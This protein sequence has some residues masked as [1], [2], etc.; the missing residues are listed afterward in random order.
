[1]R[2]RLGGGGFYLYVPVGYIYRKR[3]VIGVSDLDIIYMKRKAS[4]SAP[5]I[6]CNPG[7]GARGGV[8]AGA[9][10]DSICGVDNAGVVVYSARGESRQETAV[11]DA[12]HGY[13][14]GVEVRIELPACYCG[15]RLNQYIDR[16]PLSGL[17][18]LGSGCDV[19]LCM[20]WRRGR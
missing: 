16:K 13:K 9:R 10:L 12:V 17:H 7:E 19:D 11:F 5:G 1:M 14:C 3:V 6:Q 2:S 18:C 20:G 8:A 15:C 4:R